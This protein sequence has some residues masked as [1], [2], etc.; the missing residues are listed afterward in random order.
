MGSV[1]MRSSGIALLVAALAV[2]TLAGCGQRSPEQS[3]APGRLDESTVDMI[4]G[5]GDYAERRHR[6][7][8]AEVE[9]TR[10]CMHAAGFTWSGSASAENPEAKEGGG[11][12]I[13]QVRL[14]GYGLSD[15]PTGLAPGQAGPVADDTALR[16]ALLGAEDDLVELTSPA[17]VEYRY[18]RRGCAAQ[19]SIALYGDLDTWAR[20]TYLP[21]EVNLRLGARAKTDPRYLAKL[22]EWRA[23][24]GGTYDS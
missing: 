21:Q 7:D 13:D 1:L 5:S 14:H 12:S 10:Q 11:V 24:M 17:G 22:G 9:L 2:G 16:K 3:P 18:P 19:A 15:E 8:V 23:C 4:T 6:V 20:S